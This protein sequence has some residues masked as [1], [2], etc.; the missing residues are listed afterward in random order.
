[1]ERPWLKL[2]FTVPALT[3]PAPRGFKVRGGRPPGV[4]PL[5]LSS[6]M[7]CYGDVV[8]DGVTVSVGTLYIVDGYLSVQNDGAI[9]GNVRVDNTA[10]IDFRGTVLS[11]EMELSGAGTA[12][13][14]SDIT[15]HDLRIDI[16]PG[17]TV[18]LDC[19][20]NSA[21]LTI[22]GDVIDEIDGTLTWNN[23]DTTPF[24]FSYSKPPTLIFLDKI[25]KNP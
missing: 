6:L 12:T 18:T 4:R 3:E 2:C 25:Q 15:L 5:S 14:I 17:D 11:G 9:D 1:L 20:T 8:I 10:S 24:F 19:S 22:N 23:Y 16:N 13:I 21:T 7:I